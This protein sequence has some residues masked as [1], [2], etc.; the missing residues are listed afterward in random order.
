MRQYCGGS[1]LGDQGEAG[2]R[3][4]WR[5]VVAVFVWAACTDQGTVLPACVSG[6]DVRC[7]GG[8]RG[9][10]DLKGLVRGKHEMCIA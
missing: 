9:G 10:E 8:G 6:G 7:R 1:T 5:L 2:L 3:W 4:N